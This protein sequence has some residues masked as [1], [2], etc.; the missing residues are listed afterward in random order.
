MTVV[1]SIEHRRSL[2]SSAFIGL[3][4]LIT[5]LFEIAKTRSYF[6]RKM[7]ALA[8][9]STVRTAFKFTLL[10]L[11]EVPKR[12]DIL[13]EKFR[14]EA[15]KET[16][17]GFWTRAFFVWLNPTFLLGFR[18]V[19]TVEDL[20]PLGPEFSSERLFNRLEEKWKNSK[21]LITVSVPAN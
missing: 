13:D 18:R 8:A 10:G 3:Y 17:S 20:G 19:I 5:V 16:V 4:L 7:Q 9:L 1:I 15:G 14:K 6:L 11:L 21:S 2:Q 12:R